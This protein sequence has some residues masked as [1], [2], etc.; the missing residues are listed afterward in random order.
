MGGWE[1]LLGGDGES[2]GREGGK[3]RGRRERE[4]KIGVFGEGVIWEGGRERGTGRM[5]RGRKIRIFP[6]Q[7]LGREGGEKHREKGKREKSSDFWSLFVFLESFG[8]EGVKEAGKEREGE[9]QGEGKKK[10]KS[11][12]FQSS[13]LGGREGWREEEE[14]RGTGRRNREKS[15]FWRFFFF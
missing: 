14:E 6:E 2:P 5:E 12:F 8:R 11:K 9:G 10:E 4:R 3:G 15:E 1:S 13:C 7:V